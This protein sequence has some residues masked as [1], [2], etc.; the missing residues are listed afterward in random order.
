MSKLNVLTANRLADGIAVWLGADGEWHEKIDD[1]FVARHDEALSGL[2]DAEK[3]AA[4]DNQVVDVAIIDVEERAG[5]LY[6]LRLRE[7][8]RAAGPTVRTDLGKQV[9]F[10]E[11]EGHVEDALAA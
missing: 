9:E 7:R 3:V 4:F 6:A 10:A 11:P 5:H 1:A 2:Q 8:I